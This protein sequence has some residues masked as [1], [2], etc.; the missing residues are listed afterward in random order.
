MKSKTIP[1][2]ICLIIFSCIF[3]PAAQAH[4]PRIVGPS[5]EITNI[6]NPEISQA[7][8]G[9]LK[10]EP[11][12]F[13][14]QSDQWFNLYVGIL[15]PD[16]ADVDKDVSVLVSRKT[17]QGE[18]EMFLLDGQNYN[19][20]LFYEEFGGDHYFQGP[21][22]RAFDSPDDLPHGTRVS[23]GTYI[24]KVYSSDNQGKYVLVVG[25][26]EEFPPAEIINTIITLPQLKMNFFDKSPFAVYNSLIGVYLFI[27]L[28]AVVF[29][30]ALV[31]WLVIKKRFKNKKA[32]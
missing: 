14:V 3:I 15:V 20:Q 27:P 23:E 2:L 9:Q 16:V 10:G 26:K 22:L 28:T 7:F 17:E 11:A 25:E 18:Q 8:Y 21:E 31:V 30:I 1:F 32:V 12:L 5:A 19:W 13:Q 24:I 4:Q 29:L 6:H